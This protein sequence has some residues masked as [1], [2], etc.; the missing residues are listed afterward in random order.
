MILFA[1]AQNKKL[2][3]GN[4]AIVKYSLA[5]K[6]GT[7]GKKIS[8]VSLWTFNFKWLISGS[9]IPGCKWLHCKVNPIF[10]EYCKCS[11]SL[12]SHSPPLCSN[13]CAPYVLENIGETKARWNVFL[14]KCLNF[15]MV[16]YQA[17]E[18]SGFSTNC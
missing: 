16:I 13:T 4:W 3:H 11:L 15:R 12:I 14:E 6:N 9:V 7:N 10:L 8:S 2:F 17:S 5:Q 18:L 1:V